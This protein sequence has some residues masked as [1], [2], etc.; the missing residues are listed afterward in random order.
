M[1]RSAPV[2]TLNLIAH[3][4][5]TDVREPTCKPSFYPG[6]FSVMFCSSRACLG[7][8]SS[9]LLHSYGRKLTDAVAEPTCMSSKSISLTPPCAQTVAFSC[10]EA[11]PYVCPEPVL[12]KWSHLYINGAK[13]HDILSHQIL[14][15]PNAAKRT[16][17]ANLV[18]T[19]PLLV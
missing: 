1:L 6:N 11:T 14:A 2:L 19:T 12:G 10:I 7:K 13:R 5:V 3:G 9:F 15:H 17:C 18:R 8:S 16:K 4:E